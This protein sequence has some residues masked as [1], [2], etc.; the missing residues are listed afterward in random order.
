MCLRTVVGTR[1]VGKVSIGV[2]CSLAILIAT[3]WT[4]N[5]P[6]AHAQ[7]LISC[8]GGSRAYSVVSGDTLSGIAAKFGTQWPSLASYNRIANPNLIFVDQV[9]CIPGQTSGGSSTSIQPSQPSPVQS[10]T[11]ST[12][13]PAAQGN[14]TITGMISQVFGPNAPA[15]IAVARCESGLNPSATNPSSGAAGL[16]QFLPSTW[17]GT[18]QAAS[19][20]YNAWANTVAA[21]EV[22]VRDGYSW[23]EWSCQP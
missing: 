2:V 18:S 12:P 11:G 5:A 22:F 1:F 19:S 3:L 16:F 21:H 7:A 10:A 6:A 9:I 17:R 14:T 8:P 23:R 20:P 13:P 15:A 4:T